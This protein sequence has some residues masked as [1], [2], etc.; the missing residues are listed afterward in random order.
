MSLTEK[1]K[2]EKN[3][4]YEIVIEDMTEAG[5]GL[6][7]MDGYPLFVKDAIVGDTILAK[8]I[9]AKKN[10][11]YGRL[12]KVLSPSEFRVAPPCPVARQ[13]GGCTIQALSYEKQL[14]LKYKKVKN[15]LERIGGFS[16]EEIE[17]KMEG[18]YG[19]EIP[20]HYRNKAQF[21]VGTDKD[22]KLIAGFYAGRTHNIIE[23][24]DCLIQNV[25][26]KEI[27]DIVLSYMKTNHVKPYDERQHKGC[28]RHILTRVG[29]VTGE[30][31]VCLIINGSKKQLKK[32]EE[33][34]ESLK[35]IEGM[36]S[37]VL[38]YNSE[39]TN[40][41]L[42]D[43][44]ETIWGRDYIVDYIGDVEYQIGPLSFY[45]V[46]PQQTKR[47]YDKVME[48]ANLKGEE[49]VWDLYCGIGTISL[50][51]AQKAKKVYGV[52]IVE[53]AIDDARK[54]AKR[55]GMTHTQFFVGKAEEIFPMQYEK[56]HEKADVVVVDPPRKGCDAV[57]LNTIM[58]MA[59]ERVVY[60]S[61]DP[62]TL[63]R[64]LRIL[65]ESAYEVE[66]VAVYDQF[67]HSMHVE[68]VVL[69]SQR[70]ADDYVEVELELSELDL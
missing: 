17:E 40:R 1:K 48:Y 69:L 58:D 62:G 23:N 15:C 41:I 31:M 45:Q 61:C 42:G 7:K 57:L 64:D 50:F 37:I 10:Y 43:E 24:T 67:C 13:C 47:L 4:I 3:D 59:P 25:K 32:K 55:N 54:N 38:N 14:D 28:V 26:N 63:A 52:E 11:G 27:L 35:K 68:S 20:Y 18:I 34:V 6:G 66:K 39:K 70:K 33:L 22:G 21:P 9:K 46:N 8:V 56:N 44:C 5:E 60:V 30:I 16:K 12:E 19:M 49:I 51:L 2:I 29:Y 53:G 65:C 36:T